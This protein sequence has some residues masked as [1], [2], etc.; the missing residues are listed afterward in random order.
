M[1]I[2]AFLTAFSAFVMLFLPFISLSNSSETKETEQNI[3]ETAIEKEKN[4]SVKVLQVSSGKVLEIDSFDYIVGV[5][6]A[7]MPA[8][9]EKEAL[10]AQAVASYTYLLWL[11]ENAD[12]PEEGKRDITDSSSEHQ[13]FKTKEQLKELWGD[14]YEKY[15]KKIEEAVKEV[16][17]QYLTYEGEVAMTVF[18]GISAGK[19]ESAKNVW[20]KDIPYLASVTSPG[21]KLASEYSSETD[22]SENELKNLMKKENISFDG[23]IEIT[24]KTDNGYVKKIKVGNTEIT[25]DTLRGILNLKSPYFTVKK[26]KSSFIFTTTGKGHGIGMSQNSADYMARQGSDYKEILAH[27]YKGTELK[28]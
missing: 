6:A 16:Y 21:D 19:T 15:I 27:F 10:K 22:F 24:E 9:F 1:K 5:V 25:G 11:K 28:K 4:D 23:N 14:N 18:H 20:N 13:G 7:E 2:Y 8:L 26:E 12:N 17:P 3:T